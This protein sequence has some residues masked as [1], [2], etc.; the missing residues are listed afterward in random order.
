MS[1][2]SKKPQFDISPVILSVLLGL[3]SGVV[4]MLYA[5]AY[6]VPENPTSGS[7]VQQVRIARTP[8]ANDDRPEWA[9]I[10][11]ES[12]TRST[13]V[14][15][16]SLPPGGGALAGAFVPGEAIGAASVLT[17]DGWLITHESALGGADRGANVFVSV[18]GRAYPVR[19]YL[20]DPYSGVA[21][22]RVNATNLP[23]TSFGDDARVRAGDMLFAVDAAAGL[24]RLEMTGAGER[25]ATKTDEYVVSS[26]KIGTVLRTADVGAILPGSPVVGSDGGTVGIYAGKS[27]LGG[28]LIPLSSFFSQIASVLRDQRVLRPALGVHYVD[29]SRVADLS[30]DGSGQRR[31][32]QLQ[33]T[34]DGKYPAVARRSA[35]ENAGLRAGDII[36]S[37]GDEEV[38]AKRALAD[39]LVEYDSGAAVTLKVLRGGTER[40]VNVILGQSAP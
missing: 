13:A 12:V 33:G 29:L 32:A 11:L 23:V 37:V 40:S 7:I 1:F 16:R 36:T 34:A 28:Y 20:V 17:S 25:P 31:G 6:L 24:H 19:A 39:I 21:F 22:L 18:N 30:A 15:Y 10:R 26:E 35:A 38:S 8:A 14:L 2:F 3:L 9:D 5:S 27:A 4:G